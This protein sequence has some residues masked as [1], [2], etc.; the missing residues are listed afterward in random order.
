MV[1]CESQSVIPELKGVQDHS[2]K[3][4]SK[5]HDITLNVVKQVQNKIDDSEKALI[6]TEINK[7]EIRIITNSGNFKA[8]FEEVNKLKTGNELV[9]EIDNARVT[10]QHAQTDKNG[11][12]FM[13]K[14]EFRVTDIAMGFQ[15]KAVLHSYITK[16]FFMIQGKGKMHDKSFCRDHFHEHVM[17]P[18]IKDVME[19]KGMAIMY[20][21]KRLQ[22]IKTNNPKRKLPEKNVKCE[23]C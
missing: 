3:G 16:G 23:K 20:M 19:V 18:L 7:E 2:I 13:I 9:S 4:R 5:Q 10:D 11:V 12:P 8:I 22:G 14:T 6:M 21:N 1:K 15:Q 17:K